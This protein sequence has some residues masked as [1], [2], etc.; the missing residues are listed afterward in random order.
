MNSDFVVPVENVG[1]VFTTWAWPF[2]IQR[3]AEIDRYFAKLQQLNP[4]LWNGR[5]LLLRDHELK[6]SALRGTVFETDYASLQAGIE[7]R[8]MGQNTVRASFGVAAL[9]TSD[10]AY[11]VGVMAP[12]TRN[13]GQI[14]FPSGSLDPEDLVGT[15]VDLFGNVRR[16]LAEETGLSPEEF[17]YQ[18][19]W[20]AVFAGPRV[21]IMKI[22]QASERGENLCSQIL[23]NLAAQPS[24][25]FS[26]IRLVRD[27]ADLDSQMPSW[28]TSFFKYIWR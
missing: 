24:P 21:A 20:H 6:D 28:M 23:A 10:Q 15:K 5:V 17:E 4:T 2:A 7:W 27:A 13:A 11:V 12:H 26:D 22:V 3:R 19:G 16:E 25:E 8:V 18:S 14:Y 1:F 9:R